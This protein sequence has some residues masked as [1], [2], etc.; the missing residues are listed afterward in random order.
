MQILALSDQVD[1]RVYSP[2]FRENQR[3]IAIALGC[4]DLPYSYME[5]IATMFPVPCF[6][7]HGNHDHVEYLSNHQVLERPGGWV[8]VD[9]RTAKA[10]GLIV[11]GLEGSRRYRPDTPYQYDEWEIW[12]K[13]WRMSLFLLL[14]RIR[15]GRYLD[16]L[17]THAPPWG[18]HDAEDLPHQGFYAFLQFMRRFR[19]AYLLHGHQHT[20]ARDSWQTRYGQTEVVNVYPLRTLQVRKSDG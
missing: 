18:I 4:G 12:L 1:R 14:N 9:G 16:I 19:P 6:Y 10:A 17:I 3:D 2:D 7:V 5:Y 13:I 15:E 20:S 8:N 11:G